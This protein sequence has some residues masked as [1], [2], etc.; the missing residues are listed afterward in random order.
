MTTQ[1]RLTSNTVNHLEFNYIVELRLNMCIFQDIIKNSLKC[2]LHIL[3]ELPLYHC[4]RGVQCNE[5]KHDAY[6]RIYHNNKVEINNHQDMSITQALSFKITLAKQV[7]N[8]FYKLKVS[9]GTPPHI[10]QTQSLTCP[11]AL[12]V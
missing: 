9:L 2:H 3:K 10:T 7:M 4:I 6:D 11:Q 8:K 1:L 12:R 5:N